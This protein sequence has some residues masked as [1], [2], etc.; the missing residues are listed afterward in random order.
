MLITHGDCHAR[1]NLMSKTKL[2]SMA[3]AA[4]LLN[5]LLFAAY[6]LAFLA[7]NPHPTTSSELARILL[8]GLRL[9]V[10]LM[11]FEF[12][13]IGLLTMLFRRLKAGRIMFWF[14]GLFAL[15]AFVCAAN[16][17]TFMERNQNA[18]DLTLPYITSP[19]QIYLAVMPFCQDHWIMMLG[20]LAGVVGWFLA[21]W[22]IARWVEGQEQ[23]TDLW[24]SP[25][26]ISLSLLVTLSPLM[27]TWQPIIKQKR[28]AHNKGISAV[29]ASSKYY[30]HFS[31]YRQNE[32]AINP[33]YE[34]VGVQ[35]PTALNRSLPY[36]LTEPQLMEEWSEDH[37]PVQDAQY[38]VE[39]TVQGKADSP[40]ENIVI[41]QVEGL[42]GSVLQQKRKG[43][44]VTPFLRGLMKDDLYFPNTFQNANFT[45]GGVFSTAS[46][47]PKQTWDEPTR[48]FTSYELHG[49]YGSLAHI[50][51]T[52]NYTHYFCEGFR[53]SGDDFLAFMSYQ[54][55]KVLNYEAF[56]ERLTA[57]HQLVVADSPLGIHDGYMMQETADLLEQCPTRVTAHL[58]TCS[59]HSP[60]T[61]PP[62][63]AGPFDEPDLNTF[64][65]LD[66]SIEAFAQ[67]IEHSPKLRG[68]TLLVVLGD[69]TSVTFGNNVMERLRI[70][71]FFFAP[72]LPRIEG[73]HEHW[74]QQIDV[75]PSVLGL[76][77]GKH[78]YAGMGR[79]LF[80]P[81]YQFEG[82]T[83]GTR[84]TGYFLTSDWLLRYHPFGGKAELFALTNGE[85]ATEDLAANHAEIAAE[86]E[87]EAYARMELAK[88]LAVA[89]RIYPNSS[90]LCPG[91]MAS[92]R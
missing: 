69:H 23:P 44:P 82:V 33:L 86:L 79:N 78:T 36:R 49:F 43:K 88:R 19:Y 3:G 38:P 87:F 65:Y 66:A 91:A 42:S 14:W 47:V 71:L 15:H 30:T 7:N 61:V 11:G 68:K 85:A 25:R 40:I 45:S 28:G 64:A 62:S 1:P 63:F 74:A 32:A 52:S 51:G 8:S 53:Q 34:F 77:R 70:P 17:S 37:G 31:D 57:K 39:Q 48:R 76:L 59:T 84:D 89:K 92:Q 56:K 75:V 29:F 21:G 24:G 10:A 54:G 67:R 12:A 83:S 5:C 4:L 73:N 9:D 13:L 55:C 35:I 60:W 26:I 18:G 58:M 2:L 90:P 72:G 41:I 27:M 50:L 81:Q 80:D 22:E 6:R 46:G 20:L 16:L